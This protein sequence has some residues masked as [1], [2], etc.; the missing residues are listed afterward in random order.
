MPLSIDLYVPGDSWLYR[1]DPRAK[2]VW[3]A[4]GFALP[5]LVNHP[6]WMLLIVATTL[7]I[8]W[9]GGLP[10]RRIVGMLSVNAFLFVS[11]VL[12]WPLYLQSGDVVFELFGVDYTTVGL[13]YGTAVG[14]R[15]AAMMN[16]SVVWI[17]SSDPG[18]TILGLEMLGLHYKAAAAMSITLRFLP[19]IAAEG[20]T[21]VEAQRSR[22]L[23]LDRGSPFTRAR[24]YA[25]I[26]I[27][28]V[29]RSFLI[30]Q[31]L[32]TALDA[33]GFGLSKNRTHAIALQF[34]GADWAFVAVWVL[35]LVFGIFLRVSGYGLVVPHLI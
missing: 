18:R 35:A 19:A 20:A 14:L 15:V 8:A 11:S 17:M 25:P 3:L 7:L 5:L 30:A 26:V 27:P 28:L 34:R 24:R 10:L 1:V 32:G 2:L 21:I 12:I 9:S 23:E 33:R 13:A 22:A 6:A 31:Q 16:L 4:C 29:T